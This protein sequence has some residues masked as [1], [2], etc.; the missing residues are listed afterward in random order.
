MASSELKDKS[1]NKSLASGPYN[2]VKALL[3]K[4]N[5][6]LHN[7][8]NQ[9]AYLDHDDVN[10][11][12]L[13]KTMPEL[14]PNECLQKNINEATKLIE[15]VANDKRTSELKMD[16]T[17]EDE[18]QLDIQIDQMMTNIRKK[19]DDLF[20]RL[21]NVQVGF[22]DCLNTN[23]NI[24]SNTSKQNFIKIH[25]QVIEKTCV[26]DKGI[27]SVY[28]CDKGTLEKHVDKDLVIAT[29]NEFTNSCNELE[30]EIINDV[31]EEGVKSSKNHEHLLSMK[32]YN[33]SDGLSFEVAGGMEKIDPYTKK[34]ITKPVT[35]TICKHIYDQKSV[36]IMFLKKHFISC[37][38]I[39]CSNKHTTKKDLKYD[40][41]EQ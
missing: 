17:I 30:Q 41:I 9:N 14:N 24:I 16:F 29:V 27:G 6:L 26:F 33:T 28:Y 39:G 35:N 4:R 2:E 36:E 15:N 20:K 10:L 8:N 40:E 7:E 32:K 11:I 19:S 25:T 21:K 23:T 13:L 12:E 37:P 22:N 38:Y 31:Y 18:N 1:S 34:L 5:K 3:V